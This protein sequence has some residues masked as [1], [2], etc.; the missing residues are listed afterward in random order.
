MGSV[1]RDP[2]AV[3][4]GDQSFVRGT[5]TVEAGSQRS[6]RGTSSAF[7]ATFLQELAGVPQEL[8]YGF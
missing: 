7:V 4:Q 5:D 2:W 6:R 1:E 3:S 8:L